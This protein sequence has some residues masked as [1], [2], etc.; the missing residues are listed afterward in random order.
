ML[1]WLAVFSL[2]CM[3]VQGSEAEVS[4][5]F[6]SIS[7]LSMKSHCER[8]DLDINCTDTLLPGTKAI[9]KCQFGYQKPQNFESELTCQESGEW[10][11]PAYKCEP[12]CGRVSSHS[13]PLQIGGDLKVFLINVFFNTL[14]YFQADTLTSLK[15]PG[16]WEFTRTTHKSAAEQ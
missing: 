9:I 8:N 4:C 16:M 6:E 10:S 5:P 15:C 11:P 2:L 13:V 14:F 7:G 3:M 1:Q 12:I